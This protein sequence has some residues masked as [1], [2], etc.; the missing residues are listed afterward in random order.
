MRACS[1]FLLTVSEAYL[2]EEP[3]RILALLCVDLSLFL[4]VFVS[5]ALLQPM[6]LMLPMGHRL[7]ARHFGS[8]IATT[9]VNCWQDY[10]LLAALSVDSFVTP[11]RAGS[12]KRG[13]SGRVTTRTTPSMLQRLHHLALSLRKQLCVT[14][15]PSRNSRNASVW[16]PVCG[17]GTVPANLVTQHFSCSKRTPFF[18]R[19]CPFLCDR[20]L[21]WHHYC[22]SDFVLVGVLF[23]RS[24]V[25]Q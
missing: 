14:R 21:A 23:P 18:K 12:R 4:R 5:A 20:R 24:R 7:A 11:I 9:T 2:P 25:A 17:T 19:Q 13:G 8:L 16:L 6:V 10:L 15:N 22:I 3:R 1:A